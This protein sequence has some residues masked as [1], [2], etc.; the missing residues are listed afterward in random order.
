VIVDPKGNSWEKYRGA[1]VVTPNIKEL[2][3]I[4]GEPLGNEDTVIG[5]HAGRIRTRFSLGALLVTRSEK[6]M[7]L[8]EKKTTYHFPTQAREVFDV[9]GAGDTVVATLA[10]GLA[11]GYALG[12]SVEL[13]NKAAGIVVAKIGTAPVTIVELR[14]AI[15]KNYNAKLLTTAELVGRCAE[16]RTSG[17]TVVFTNG[18]FDILHRGHVHLFTEAKKQGD[19]LVVALNSDKSIARMRGGD[20][21]VNPE[22]DRAHLVA[23]IDGVDY[24]TLFDE[25]TPVALL[26]RIRPDVIVKGG[27]YREADVVGR[28]YAAKTVIVPQLKG[29]STEEIIRKIGG[30]S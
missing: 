13:A 5:T 25:S 28:E 24:L 19:L 20:L 3:D 6:G 10:A 11:N 15:D 8:V 7:T 2:G 27:N 9:S 17:R 1:S 23:A 30:K 4:A 16:E 21:P 14:A 12:E 18:C 29:Y 22:H 26:R